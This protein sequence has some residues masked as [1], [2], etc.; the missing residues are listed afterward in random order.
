MSA[1]IYSERVEFADVD[2]D[3]LLEVL[4]LEGIDI[5][6]AT[7]SQDPI[8]I[9]EGATGFPGA[10]TVGVGALTSTGTNAAFGR[11]AEAS[12]VDATAIGTETTAPSNWNTVVGYAAG[13]RQNGNNVVL[14]GRKSEG[15]GNDVVS[16]GE[17]T[18]A[19]ADNAT[20]VGKAAAALA[21]NASV[22]GQG[23]TVS[24]ESSTLVGQGISSTVDDAVGV[25]FDI[26]LTGSRGTVV[27]SSATVSAPD[28][29]AIGR[30]ATASGSSS[31]AIG[32]GTTVS[33][34][35]TYGV[36]DRNIFV[37][38]GRSLLLGDD[39]G[40][41][42][43]VD[44]DITS[45][46]AQGTAQSYSLH[47]DGQE[48]LTIDGEAD[49][50]G[51]I[52]NERVKI[53]V[54]LT[55][56]GGTTS[57]DEFVTGTTTVEDGIGTDVFVVDA[58]ASPPV[59]DFNSN[60]LRN[61]DAVA[62]D[63]ISVIGADNDTLRVDASAV[64]GVAL[65]VGG[66]PHVLD[67]VAGSFITTDGSGVSVNLGNGLEG[68]G[69]DSIRI[70]P[71]DIVSDGLGE[72]SDTT[73]GVVVSDL[74]GDG[75]TPTGS[76]VG[77]DLQVNPGTGLQIDGDTV[78]FDPLDDEELF[79]GTGD[80]MSQRYDAAQDDLRWADNTAGQDRMAL[81]RTTGDLS[82]EGELTEAATL[83]P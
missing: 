74:A 70:K 2:A 63:G 60:N 61:I 22:F 24:G 55:V 3:S 82:I 75:L 69:A 41:E 40:E 78:A 8:S 54:D 48:M 36:G 51:G 66:S 17:N 42:V 76:G 72:A 26:T 20:A 44:M 19:N 15:Q 56:A 14:I 28:A 13:S 21:K 53:P 18:R 35:N 46:P 43:L 9:G 81:D 32:E 10:T 65:T 25:G 77:H 67:V 11:A 80:P 38:P 58:T 71:D 1:S 12:G 47:L 7:F 16:V 62:G 33:K 30:N 45:A 5:E 29:V 34:D 49:G 59:I 52:Q 4:N 23:S 79:W 31:V 27:G 68:D 83:V 6:D 73:L 50:A 57:V 37:A 39:A 64:A